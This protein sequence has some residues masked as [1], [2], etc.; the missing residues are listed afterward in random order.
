MH[1]GAGTE[2]WVP[3]KRRKRPSTPAAGPAAAESAE[4][5][6]AVWRDERGRRSE[7]AG[8]DAPSAPAATQDE[9]PAVEAETEPEE[10]PAESEPIPDAPEPEEGEEETVSAE[11]APEAEEDEAAVEAAP[12]PKEE[13]EAAAAEAAP[14]PKEE[15]EA[16]A[17]EAAPEPEEEDEAA[18]VEAAPEEEE[19]DEAVEVEPVPEEE[20]EEDAAPAEPA[21]E[22]EEEDGAEPEKPEGPAP[23]T[24]PSVEVEAV[25]TDT[26]WEVLGRFREM[27]ARAYRN[28]PPWVVG[29]TLRENPD[30]VRTLVDE[31]EALR[32]KGDD[33]GFRDR[34]SQLYQETLDVKVRHGRKARKVGQFIETI[35]R[36]AGRTL[37]GKPVEMADLAEGVLGILSHEPF[38]EECLALME[39]GAEARERAPV[40]L[41]SVLLSASPAFRE[42]G[43]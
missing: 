2:V 12:E 40:F 5:V 36:R 7:P 17:A 35:A 3:S 25:F 11:L 23:E 4:E 22:E 20:E 10:R 19:E 1:V 42:R 8:P 31:A 29:R 39:G 41:F 38:L 30:K 21:P 14:E 43:G 33:V 32:G 13:S 37:S 15:D 9:P 18:A 6:T 26:E 16:A 34:L 28:I 24:A 27:F